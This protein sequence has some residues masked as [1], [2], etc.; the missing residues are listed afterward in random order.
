LGADRT[1]EEGAYVIQI[2]LG[3][4]VDAAFRGDIRRISREKRP[5]V[6][7]FEIV[8]RQV[9]LTRE[10]AFI[11]LVYTPPEIVGEPIRQNVNSKN[12]NAR[13][14]PLGADM[15]LRIFVMTV[16][17]PVIESTSSVDET[18]NRIEGLLV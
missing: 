10:E 2:V 3:A 9:E 1:L 6:L 8:V 5:L 14:S 13:R 15:V 18:V 11:K 16:R 17:L 12:F 7:Q 4:A